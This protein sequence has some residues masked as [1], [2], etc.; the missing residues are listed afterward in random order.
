MTTKLA[1]AIDV[2]L[3]HGFLNK[4]TKHLKEVEKQV[5]SFLLQHHPDKGGKNP[6]FFVI[7]TWRNDQTLQNSLFALQ[8][9]RHQKVLKGTEPN[10]KKIESKLTPIALGALNGIQAKVALLFRKLLFEESDFSVKDQKALPDETKKR[11][12]VWLRE[13][14]GRRATTTISAAAA[15]SSNRSSKEK[16]KKKRTLVTIG[17]KRRVP[18]LLKM[19]PAPRRIPRTVNNVPQPAFSRQAFDNLNHAKPCKYED[20]YRYPDTKRCRALKPCLQRRMTR[21]PYSQKCVRNASLR[22]VTNKAIRKQ[23]IREQNI[24]KQKIKKCK[25]GKMV[26]PLTLRCVAKCKPGYERSLA[27]KRCVKKCRPNQVRNEKTGRCR[28]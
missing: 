20:E 14:R 7:N 17:A 2:Y 6:D 21:D 27:T 18:L 28:K 8:E 16:L 9:L 4:K 15:P 13:P 24:R 1:A 23:K 19:G 12:K 26:H 22:V 10:M 5:K 25:P 11:F 3:R